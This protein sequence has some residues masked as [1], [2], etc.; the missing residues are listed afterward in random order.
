[1]DSGVAKKFLVGPLSPLSPLIGSL[2]GYRT[3]TTDE[4]V[5]SPVTPLLKG[6]NGLTGLG[7]SRSIR[8][9]PKTVK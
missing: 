3:G 4:P 6:V 5:S 1:M 7:L 8:T 9:D 2:T